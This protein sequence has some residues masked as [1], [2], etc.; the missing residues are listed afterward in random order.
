MPSITSPGIG[1]GLDIES[2]VSQLVAL[3]GQPQQQRL[4]RREATFQAELSG[5][6]TFR[7]ALDSFRTAL[8]SLQDLEEF[9]ARTV[10][11]SDEDIFTVSASNSA[12]PGSYDIEV[13]SLAKSHKLASAAFADAATY[14]GTGTLEISIDPASAE[15]GTFSVEILDSEKA[16]LADIRDAINSAANNP[17]VVASIV[18]AEDGAHLVLNGTLTGAARTMTITASGGDG[19]LDALVY[20]PDN[21]VTNLS[22]TQAA[23]DAELRIDS[24]THFS[25]TN[26]VTDAIDGLTIDL[27][28]AEEG[29]VETLQ[30]A[31]DKDQTRIQ[32][33]DFVSAYNGLIITSQ[34]LTSYDPE[35]RAAGPLQGDSLVPSLLNRLTREFNATV[36]AAYTKPASLR[37]LGITFTLEGTLEIDDDVL[38][39]VINNDFAAIGNVFAHATEGVARRFD[40]VFDEYLK[41][42]GILDTRND[43]LQASIAT[44]TSL[45]E[46]LALRLQSVESRLRS[47]FLALDTLIAELNNT[48][49]FLGAQL[50]NLPSP[51]ALVKKQ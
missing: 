29:S 31:L 35:T 33:E 43:G 18:N 19:G 22:E 23:A 49:G 9:G 37:D 46:Q 24:F 34:G 47:Q 27:V 42:D 1:S 12:A 25:S 45:R 28:S 21:L 30:I 16:T 13:V 7:S 50:A 51:G 48:S 8:E 10:F 44:I 6:G 36:P 4:D 39:E 3:E 5:L 2:L 20:D 11:S 32:I 15:G 38:D 17:G 14:V 41:A 40:N 26:T